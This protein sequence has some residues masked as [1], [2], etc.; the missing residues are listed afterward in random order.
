MLTALACAGALAGCSILLDFDATQGDAEGTAGSASNQGGTGNGSTAG[1][2]GSAGSA[3]SAGTAGSAGALS[4][5]AGDIGAGGCG[6]QF[7]DFDGDGYGDP[8]VAEPYCSPE[9]ALLGFV[10]DAT[11]C[12]DE[13]EAAYPDATEFCDGYDNDCD[14]VRDEDGCPSSCFGEVLDNGDYLVCHEEVSYLDALDTCRSQ[15]MSLVRIDTSSKND[16]VEGL[17]GYPGFSFWI[18]GYRDQQGVWAYP[19]GEP[20][21]Q[22]GAPIG[23]NYVGW[24]LDE[25]APAEG[26]DCIQMDPFGMW[27]AVLCTGSAGLVCRREPGDVLAPGPP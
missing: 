17:L 19:D 12:D 10:F 6:W 4:G 25:P 11:D 24:D 2:A 9:D 27:H 3:A 18:G 14:Q 16:E 8:V 22:D 15:Q 20:F 26:A 7:E 1:N 13:R 5:T 21:F 23:S